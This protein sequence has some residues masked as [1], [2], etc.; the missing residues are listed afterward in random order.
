VFMLSR[1]PHDWLFQH[2][3]C[4]IHHGGAGTTMAGIA[5]GRP[6][7][8]VPY[9]GDQAFWGTMIARAGAGPTPIPQKELAERL[10]EAID[11]C[12]RH[13]TPE[14]AKELALRTAVERGSDTGTHLFHQHLTPDRL[15]CTLAPSRTAVWRIK[16]TQVRLSAFAVCTLTNANLLDPADLKLSRAQ[17][18]ET[19]QGP[20]DP[21]SG[22][23]VTA[24]E[25]ASGITM[26][27]KDMPSEA[28][29]ACQLPFRG[30][31]Q[32]LQHSVTTSA[33]EGEVS[34]V[35]CGPRVSASSGQDQTTLDVRNHRPGIRRLTDDSSVDSFTPL[36]A[37]DSVPDSSSGRKQE[38]PSSTR[39]PGHFDFSSGKYQDMMGQRGLHTHKGLG[40]FAKA[41]VQSPMDIPMSFT[42]GFH[43]LPKAWGD[44]TVLSRRLTISCLARRRPAGSSA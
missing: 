36:V 39:N 34:E 25:V 17:E 6:T 38:N 1:V 44:D 15:R 14:R 21:I 18:Y 24:C 30:S 20:Y 2:V 32:Q 33:S 13:E 41:V 35:G 10:V 16:R 7:V 40:R 42:K 27:L 43:N 19:D 8:V 23:V 9:F 31:R 4:V 3:S 29:K 11:F 28:Y 37:S 22:A 5:A 12:L 26:G